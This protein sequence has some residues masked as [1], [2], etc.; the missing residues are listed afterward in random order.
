MAAVASPRLQSVRV[1]TEGTTRGGISAVVPRAFAAGVG[2]ARA[3]RVG[4]SARLF[5]GRREAAVPC[6]G[7]LCGRGIRGGRAES[8]AGGA[9]G[10]QLLARA[11]AASCWRCG[12]RGSLHCPLNS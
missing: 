7:W 3:R 10:R 2:L 4:V 1:R 6:H 8:M 12:S 5:R 11:G 9:R